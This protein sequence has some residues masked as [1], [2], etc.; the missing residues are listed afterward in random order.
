MASQTC[1]Q[2]NILLPR[3]LRHLHGKP[4]LFTDFNTRMTNFATK[5]LYKVV[6]YFRGAL[7]LFGEISFLMQQIR[8]VRIGCVSIYS[9]L[10]AV[11]SGG[12]VGYA[13]SI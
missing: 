11:W 13:C 10:I 8:V 5:A 7:G 2:T 3:N 4:I 6:T 1:F 9:F 12:V